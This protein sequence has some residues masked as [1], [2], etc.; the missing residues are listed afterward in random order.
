MK[1]DRDGEGG[2]VA[3]SYKVASDSSCQTE[4]EATLNN[5]N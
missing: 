4:S 5:I 1:T 2:G 3:E